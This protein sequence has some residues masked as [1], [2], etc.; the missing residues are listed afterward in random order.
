M[1]YNYLSKISGIGGKIKTKPEDFIVEEISIDG[2]VL[3]I[4]AAFAKSDQDGKYLHFVLQKNNWTTNSAISEIA[5]RLHISHKRFN[6]AGIKDRSAISTQLASVSDV[7]KDLIRK[8]KI[9]DISINGAWTA[10]DRVQMGEL[11]GNRF[12]ITVRDCAEN[13]E[14][15]INA[16]YKELKGK[17]PNYF[18]EQR[19]GSSRKNTH[20]IG[21]KLICGE[22]ESAA[23]MFLCDSEDEENSEAKIARQ[24]LAETT[25]FSAAIKNY[26]RHLKL[27]K[28]ML[29]HLSHHPTDFVG[30]FRKL[31]RNI[32]LL[33]IHAFQS[34]IFNSLLSNRIGEGELSLEKGEYF[35]PTNLG[36][37]DIEKHD[38]EGF[39]VG[40]L[41]G[42]NT[43]L[44][45][46][47]SAF[48]EK[49]GITKDKFKIKELPEVSSKG[50]YRT[51]LAPLKDFSFDNSVFRF[52]LPSGSYA[53]VA[54]REFLD[55]KR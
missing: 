20:K 34:H 27:E 30:A 55:S 52:S 21:E 10:K 16:I 3:E 12:T 43:P 4:G 36:F 33:F 23:M 11:L 38:S 6:V 29:D 41:I 48:L 35:C 31:P 39:V 19:F 2:Q 44:N 24:H 50:T 18:G 32:L 1:N 14:N 13:P 46:R 51:L 42:Y 26:P 45:E 22:I 49:I 37:P 40:K 15:T 9:K 17:F 28:S 53:T 54:M 5:E 25:N 47:E 8:I 7:S